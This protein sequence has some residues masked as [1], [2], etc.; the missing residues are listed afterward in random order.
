MCTSPITVKHSYKGN[1]STRYDVVPCGKCA[2]CRAKA[3]SEFAA[4]SVLE[5]ESA[6]SIGFLTLTYS[7]VSLPLLVSSVREFEIAGERTIEVSNIEFSTSY[8]SR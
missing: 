2:E 8:A 5:A 4:L 6:G 7:D 3:Q 1:F